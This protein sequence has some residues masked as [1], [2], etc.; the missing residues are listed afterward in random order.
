[1]S[2]FSLG[3]VFEAVRYPAPYIPRQKMAVLAN[4]FAS[5]NGCAEFASGSDKSQDN[6][7]QILLRS[8]SPQALN[9][10]R[11]I[12]AYDVASRSHKQSRLI[13]TNIQS[14]PILC[15]FI[16]K[17]PSKERCTMLTYDI[18]FPIVDH[19]TENIMRWM[20][21]MTITERGQFLA[22]RGIV[23]LL[24]H[25]TGSESYRTYR[26]PKYVHPVVQQYLNEQPEEGQKAILQ[27]SCYNY[28]MT[29]KEAGLKRV[30]EVLSNDEYY[31]VMFDS[32]RKGGSPFAW[33]YGNADTIMCVK[34]LN[35]Q[36]RQKLSQEAQTVWGVEPS[37]R[38]P[39][40]YTWADVVA[41]IPTSVPSTCPAPAGM[42]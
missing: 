22:Q 40:S 15:A 37:S 12:F 7:L 18:V 32:V 4:N 29:F 19:G 11:H 23:G 3:T 24:L 42:G 38:N 6:F 27:A 13:N 9:I 10:L 26:A 35:E 30:L 20:D 1:M 41:S 33:E 25:G 36:N 17:L 34:A 5:A 39:R 14:N 31:Q 8:K 28:V 2:A 21:E 16:D